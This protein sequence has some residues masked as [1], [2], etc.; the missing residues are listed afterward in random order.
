MEKCPPQHTDLSFLKNLF[1]APL[2]DMQAL[3]SLTRDQTRVPAG[4]PGFG[5]YTSLRLFLP[6]AEARFLTTDHQGSPHRALF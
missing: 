2:C 4:T 1:L 6:L 3:S 5:A